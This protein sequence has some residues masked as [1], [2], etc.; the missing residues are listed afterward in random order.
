MKKL[1]ILS[2]AILLA[3]AGN[4]QKFG[5]KAGYGMSGYLINYWSPAGS[6]MS[7]GL[8]AGLVAELDL[9]VIGVRADVTFNQLGSNYDSKKE[10][11]TDWP[12]RVAGVEYNY[13]QNINYLNIGVSVKK[14]FGPAYVVLGPYFGYAINGNQKSTW[15]GGP[16]AVT[17]TPGTGTFDIFSEPNTSFNP[18]AEYSDSNNQGGTG[19][20]HKKT[21]LGVNL[22]LGVSFS[23]IF[24]EANAGLGLLNFINTSSASYSAANYATKDDK[25]IAITGDASMKNLGIGLSVGYM[26]GK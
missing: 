9:K 11:D 23:G 3:F 24:V 4:A 17:P 15:I 19:D 25:T 13:N 1:F 22:A 14:G 12:L 18:L 2:I 6:G 20:L 16:T 26:F 21:D 8:N 7:T 5:V 10:T